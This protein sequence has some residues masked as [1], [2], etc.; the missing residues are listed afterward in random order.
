M[1]K[2]FLT[3]ALGAGAMLSINAQTETETC[4]T[5]TESTVNTAGEWYVGTG[6][7]S[8]VAWTEWAISPT[9][10]YAFTDDL[11]AGLSVQQG[12][13]TNDTGET[14]AGTLNLDVHARYFF[15]DFFG[16]AGTQGLTSDFSLNVGVGKLFTLD[17]HNL[18]LDPRLVLNTE[19]RTTNLQIGFG[20]KF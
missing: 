17:S 20:F 6:N 8:N 3:L 7:V 9:V 12:T 1:K 15:G 5:A 11:M 4:C 10:G 18:Y 2:L 14:E 16:Y 19:D 13:V